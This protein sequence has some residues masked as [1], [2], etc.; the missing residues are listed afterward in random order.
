MP[1]QEDIEAFI[2]DLCKVIII[3]PTFEEDDFGDDSITLPG[4]I[5][6]GPLQTLHLHIQCLMSEDITQVGNSDNSDGRLDQ[7]RTKMR[8][9]PCIHHRRLGCSECGSGGA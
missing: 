4:R 3:E 2:C 6:D 5:K 9:G 7:F 1:Y 8:N